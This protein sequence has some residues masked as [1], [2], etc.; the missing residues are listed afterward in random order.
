LKKK[1]RVILVAAGLL[2]VGNLTT[3]ELRHFSHNPV[4]EAIFGSSL[5]HVT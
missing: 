5:G 3:G 4:I 2:T 1:Y